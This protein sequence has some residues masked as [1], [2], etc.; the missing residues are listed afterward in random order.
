MNIEHIKE[1]ESKKQRGT[2]DS[3][4]YNKK[5][6]RLKKENYKVKLGD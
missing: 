5:V 2:E 1:W 4:N 3:S 6:D